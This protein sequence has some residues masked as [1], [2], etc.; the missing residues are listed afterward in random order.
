MP[1]LRLNEQIRILSGTLHLMTAQE[2][3]E[4]PEGPAVEHLRATAVHES[5]LNVVIVTLGHCRGLSA[6]LADMAV[7]E[8]FA[9]VRQAQRLAPRPA[10]AYRAL[11]AGLLP[12]SRADPPVPDSWLP[13]ELREA[14]YQTV[15]V[16]DDARFGVP[17]LN[18]GFERFTRLDRAAPEQLAAL[19]DGIELARPF[20]A[21]AALVDTRYSKG[22]SLSGQVAAAERV[23]AALPALLSALPENTLVVACSDHGLCFGEGNCWGI[24]RDHPAHRD[25]FVA[26][27]RLDGEPLP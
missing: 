12:G 21:F 20:F 7:L 19:L 1:G 26:R 9:Q 11:F 13:T 27:F 10:G 18:T 16:G 6:S 8:S 5:G 23:D 14:G 2:G 4:R 17:D 3:H 25:V 24:M 22:L 15:C